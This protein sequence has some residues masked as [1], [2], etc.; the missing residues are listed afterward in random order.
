MFQ[1]FSEKEEIMTTQDFVKPEEIGFDYILTKNEVIGAIGVPTFNSK[2]LTNKQSNDV[3]KK[4]A[5]IATT[6]GKF[7]L[8]KESEPVDLSTELEKQQLKIDSEK[9]MIKKELRISYLKLLKQN[10]EEMT[11]FEKKNYFIIKEEYT[12]ATELE[13]K[14]DALQERLGRIKKELDSLIKG[15]FKATICSGKDI[16]NLLEININ[17][18]SAQVNRFMIE[19]PAFITKEIEKDIVQEYIDEFEKKRRENGK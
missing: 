10:S 7:Q 3:L 16:I 12:K 14:K 17:S 6:A 2:L 4:F 11:N 13:E 9:N 8:K 5:R 18:Y 15:N 1:L 19:S